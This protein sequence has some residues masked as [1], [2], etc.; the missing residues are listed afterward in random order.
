MKQDKSIVGNNLEEIWQQFNQD[1]ISNDLHDYSTTIQVEDKS[2]SLTTVSSPGGS[3][4]GGYDTT[5]I[6]AA[7]PADVNFRFAIQPED[8]LNKIG[9]LFGM[10]D[11]KTGYAEFDDNVIVKTNDADT[12]KRI[13]GNN[14]I[15]QLFQ[16]LSGYSFKT[17]HTEKEGDMLELYIQHSIR[18]SGELRKV[19]FAFC[20]VLLSLH[21]SQ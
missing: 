13:F 3:E 6:S 15:R 18:N 14:E 2:I 8:F 10:Q 1:Y 11:I 16:S 4:E 19:F 5:T 7:I 20:H 9:K 21:K 17:T 12:F